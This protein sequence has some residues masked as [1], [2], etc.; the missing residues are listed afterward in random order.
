MWLLKGFFVISDRLQ[1][2]RRRNDALRCRI[3]SAFCDAPLF[4]SQRWWGGIS[5]FLFWGGPAAAHFNSCWGY[6]ST[7]PTPWEIPQGQVGMA[8]DR[9]FHTHIGEVVVLQS[10]FVLYG[11]GGRVSAVCSAGITIQR[12]VRESSEVAPVLQIKHIPH[13]WSQSLTIYT[14]GWLF[15]ACSHVIDIISWCYL[16]FLVIIDD[17]HKLKYGPVMTTFKKMPQTY[18]FF[19]FFV[20]IFMLHSLLFRH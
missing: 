12:E 3:F 13:C 16:S 7:S 6:Y 10:F 17:E 19:S 18:V 11:P 5:L 4:S 9:G 14:S 15:F 20:A 1:H 8:T 2:S